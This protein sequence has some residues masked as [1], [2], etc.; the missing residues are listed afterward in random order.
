MAE[1]VVAAEAV[2]P[3][4]AELVVQAAPETPARDPN[5][6]YT[7]SEIDQITAKVR[8]N[9]R[10]RTKKEIEAY[11]QGRESATAPKVEPEAKPKDEAP[12]REQFG[13]Y[14]EFLEAKTEYTSRRAAREERAT[15]AKE[16]AEKA[17][18]EAKTKRTQEF[19]SKVR[20]KYPDM[21]SR[22]E[23]VGDKPMFKEVQEAIAESEFGPDILNELVSNPQ[24]FDRLAKMSPAS[25]VRE[26]GKIE[27]RLELKATPANPEPK[28]VKQPSNAP[29]PIKPIVGKT[30]VGDGE[31]PHD[32]PEKWALW[33]NKQIAQRRAG[34]K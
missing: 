14:E 5:K 24:E 16:D 30:E 3:V 13:S 2:K 25:A 15:A 18:T 20:E 33:R 7:Q 21:D 34:V 12:T 6:V 23:D 8:K 1:E 28:E 19:Q 32:Q 10:Y 4:E 22:L 29:A 26:V 31:P 17:E 27:A 9:E 11:Y